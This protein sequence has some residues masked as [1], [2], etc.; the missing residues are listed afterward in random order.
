MSS[1]NGT[2][3]ILGSVIASMIL[4]VAYTPEVWPQWLGW[5]RPLWIYLTVIFWSFEY[6]NRLGLVTVWMI[7]LLTD[8]LLADMLGLNAFLLASVTYLGWRL[9]ERFRMYSALQQ[10]FVIFWLLFGCELARA[11]T[12]DQGWGRLVSWEIILPA[13][14]S[15]LIWP[16]VRRFMQKLCSRVEVQ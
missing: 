3:L 1:Y 14:S 13:L 6:P 15:M 2:F 10:S 9:Y 7:G 8:V 4:A 5:F 16:L 11:I 12:Q